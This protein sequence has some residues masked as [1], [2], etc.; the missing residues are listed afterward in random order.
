MHDSDNN[1]ETTLTV[2]QVAARFQVHTT[3]IQRW[4]KKQYF[5]GARKR[6]PELNSP[7][8]VPIAD[9]KLL[10][11]K[12]QVVVVTD[13]QPEPPSHQPPVADDPDTVIAP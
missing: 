9:I 4:I 1:H 10:E 13:D 6:G 12:L 3:T 11:E 8:L 7:Y 2:T 5:P